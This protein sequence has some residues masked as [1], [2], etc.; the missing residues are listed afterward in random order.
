MNS[1]YK[2]NYFFI[3]FLATFLL[4]IYSNNGY[5][6]SP[7][8]LEQEIGDNTTDWVDMST[9]Q[10]QKKVKEKYTDITSV[11]YFSDGKTLNATIWLLFPFKETPPMKEVDYGMFIDADFNSKTGYGGLDYKVELQWKNE[12]KSW[13]KVV[14]TWSKNGKERTIDIYPNFTDFFEKGK[15]FVTISVELK[16]ILYPQKYKVL[17][18]A[19][20]RRN[21][22]V[23]ISDFTRWIAIP[24]LEFDISTIPKSIELH[25]GLSDNIQV[26]INSTQGYAPKINLTLENKPKETYFV[27]DSDEIILPSYGMA[28]IPIKIT[29]TKDEVLGPHTFYVTVKS[30]FPSDELIKIQGV[31]SVPPENVIKRSAV[32]LNI[33]PELDFFDIIQMSWGKVGDFAQFIY[34]ILAGLSPFIYQQIRN[35]TKHSNTKNTDI[36]N[37]S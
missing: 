10:I 19:D 2:N 17:F 26:Q 29:P 20:F 12:S 13:T 9:N 7:S 34:G 11:D 3:I 25:Q 23:L 1:Y 6:D 28:T 36:N 35:L 8:F 15:Y 5:A 24:P 4:F 22:G 21:D 18:Y 32:L 27:Y 33:Q 31:H 16:K 37:N 30:N 14:E